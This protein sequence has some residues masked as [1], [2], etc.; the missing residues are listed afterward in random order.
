[1]LKGLHA[2]CQELDRGPENGGQKKAL[3]MVDLHDPVVA[4]TKGAPRVRRQGGRKR[5]C[6]RCRKTG[7]TKRHCNADRSFVSKSEESKDFQA[8]TLGS[9]ESSPTEW[10]RFEQGKKGVTG[11]NN[12]CAPIW[13]EASGSK[14]TSQHE[15]SAAAG[16]KET[17]EWEPNTISNTDE[18]IAQLMT[19][20]TYLSSRLGSSSAA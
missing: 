17:M 16:H 8:T 19:E 4:K 5:R 1:A 20:I 14:I 15:I 10:I 6:T 12:L 13:L 2:L 18:V 11:P 3:D 9:E 7:H